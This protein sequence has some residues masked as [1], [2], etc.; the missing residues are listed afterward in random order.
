MYNHVL[1]SHVSPYLESRTFMP[2]KINKTN[3]PTNFMREKKKQNHKPSLTS[4]SS[5]QTLDEQ[6]ELL[7]ATHVRLGMPGKPLESV[8]SSL[9]PEQILRPID[10]Y[11]NKLNQAALK[12]QLVQYYSIMPI[13]D[14]ELI[15]RSQQHQ[16][17]GTHSQ[18]EV[19]S[20]S[21]N[22][23]SFSESSSD[24]GEDKIPHKYNSEHMAKH[25]RGVSDLSNA[26]NKVK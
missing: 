7:S 5:L 3:I 15:N 14:Q 23:K 10:Q 16:I 2:Q 11:G 4:M 12:N 18:K 1:T 20:D 17:Q 8:P 25:G 19:P 9:N 24:H 6:E 13:R 21:V 26:S 22:S